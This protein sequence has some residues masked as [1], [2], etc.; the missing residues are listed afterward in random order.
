MA[1][2]L[3]KNMNFCHILLSYLAL[4]SL[5]SSSEVPRPRGVS[6]SRASL[7]NPGEDFTCFDGSLTIPFTHINDDYCDCLDGSDEPGTAACPN[8]VF[9]CTNAGHK[10]LNIASSRVN[11]GVCDCCDGSDE[12]S[13]EKTGCVN[14]CNELGRSA[15]EEAQKKAD[16]LKAGKQLRA[17]LIQKGVQLRQEK[18]EQLTELE[19]NRGEAE[20]IKE[21]KELLKKQIEELENAALAK[22]REI[23]EE[24]RKRKEEE[25]AEKNKKEATEKFILLDSNGD[26]KIDISELQTRKTFDQDRNGEVSEEEAKYFLNSKEEVE[27][28]EFLADSW[29]KIKPYMLIEDGFYKPPE[30]TDREETQTQAGNEDIDDIETNNETEDSDDLDHEEPEEEEDE[31]EEPIEKA[32]EP[33]P[34]VQYDE[35]TQK[36]ID[37]ANHARKE[38]G[39]AEKE[40]NHIERQVKDI[41]DYLEKDFG[42]EEEF[43]TLDGQCFEYT[44]YEYIYKLCPFDSAVQ[45]PKSSSS[46]TRLGVWSKW[47]GPED[48]HYSMMLYDRGQSCWNGPQRSTQ[49][50]LS[51]GGENK[52]TAVS[53]PNRCEYLFDFMTPA[54]CKDVP[55]ESHDDIHDEL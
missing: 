16:L 14:N 29:T 46:E 5:I 9:H 37:Q 30:E 18:K 47:T 34:T 45:K 8:G 36:L 21:E 40:V 44:D 10:S 26:G 23:E 50:R 49:V 27:F 43:A 52:V 51:C 32:P 35:D 19:K 38:F 12:Y 20:K 33:T 1:S 53:E 13:N 31:E 28:D 55:S 25:E 24:E 2:F 22:Y 6:L 54:A 7:Y 15:R 4:I 3:Q 17:D 11:D 39:D 48:D 41:Q 42:P